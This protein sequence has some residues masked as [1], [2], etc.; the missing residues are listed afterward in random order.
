MWCACMRV[1]TAR[2]GGWD[3]CGGRVVGRLM[4]P[5]DPAF[6]WPDPEPEIEIDEF[7]AADAAWKE[8]D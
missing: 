4:S 8:R 1:A 2:W 7:A 6:Y 3:D 5:D